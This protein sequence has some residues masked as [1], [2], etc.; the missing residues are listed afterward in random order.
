MKKLLVLI[1]AMG[2]TLWIGAKTFAAPAT[3]MDLSANATTQ[4]LSEGVVSN[5]F[6]GMVELYHPDTTSA[7]PQSDFPLNLNYGPHG[8]PGPGYGHGHGRGGP[9]YGPPPELWVYTLIGVVVVALLTRDD[10]FDY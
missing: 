10:A 2:L 9:G 6:S 1:A 5:G 8:G 7:H 3:N 4:T